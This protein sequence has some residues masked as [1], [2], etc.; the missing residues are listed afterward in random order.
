MTSTLPQIRAGETLRRS[1][2]IGRASINEATRTVELSFSSETPVE[3]YFG[4]EILDHSPAAVRLGRLNGGGAVLLEHD[5]NRQVG[6][7]EKAW[8]GNDRKGRA[9]IRFGKG[10]LAD[11]GFKDMQDGIRRLVSV[12]YRI[13]KTETITQ[14]GGVET[15]RV[16]D[17]EPFEIS[18]VSIPADETVGVGR[19][20]SDPTSPQISNHTKMNNQIDPVVAERNRVSTIL[21]MDTQAQRQGIQIDANRAISDGVSTDQFREQL[22]QSLISRQT[23]FTPGTPAPEYSRSERRDV[24]RYS[25]ARAIAGAAEGR[26][27]GIEKEMSD[28]L[29]R[30]MGRRPQG[31][32]IPNEILAQRAGMSVGLDSGAYGGSAVSTQLTD[33]LGALRPRLAVAA[34][35]ATILSGLSG[36]VAIPRVSATTAS[37]AA[38]TGTLSEQTPAVDQLVMS[39]KRLGAFSVLSKQ[40]VTQTSGDIENFVR[41]DLLTALATALDAAAISG[42]GASNQPTGILAASGIGSVAGGTNGLAPSLAHLLALVAAVANAN[43]DEGQTGFLINNKTEAKLRGTPRVASTDSEMLLAEGQMTLIGR[44]MHVSNNVPSNLTKGSSSGVCSAIIFGNFADLVIGQWGGGIDLLVD[45]YT[46]ATSG[47]L[48]LVAQGFF[49][50]LVRRAESFA[51]MKDALTA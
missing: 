41:N 38:E 9:S 28:E 4:Q 37:W 36:N 31:F 6:V 22:Y 43:A 26:L 50:I 19:G 29:A 40:L 24:A 46:L 1:I 25:L 27:D 48:R 30:S 44:K 21:E 5:R 16:T 32:F 47:Q 33:L 42:S 17:W 20:L 34:A 2:D 7:I 39:P 8:I 18:I 10:D 35:G 13:H 14:P 51:A 12:G 45:P 23:P 11:E 3:R 15:V 49:D